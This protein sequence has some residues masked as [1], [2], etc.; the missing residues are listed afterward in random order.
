[1]ADI[2]IDA[3]TTGNNE[4]PGENGATNFMSVDVD[5]NNI[6]HFYQDNNSDLVYS[7]STDGGATWGAAVTVHA[8]LTSAWSGPCI[9]FDKWTSGNNGT[10]I[11]ISFLLDGI[12]TIDYNTLDTS[13]DTLSSINVV[14]TGLSL[15]Y[16][17][18]NVTKIIKD[19]GGNLYLAYSGWNGSAFFGGMY[20]STD[21]GT[22]WTSRATPWESDDN[23]GPS[24]QFLPANLADNHDLW[25]IFG[26]RSAN[27]YSLKT[28]DDSADSW[29]ETS[30]TTAVVIDGDTRQTAASI[31]HSDGHLIL[32][33]ASHVDNAA[34][35][36][37]IYDIN[38]SGSI[39]AKTNIITDKDDWS[40]PVVYIDQNTNNIYVGWIGNPD[41][42]D[43]WNSSLTI[44]KN[45]STDGGANWGTS[46]QYS[47]DAATDNKAIW[48]SHSSPGNAA[49]RWLLS[50]QADTAQ[51]LITNFANSVVVAPAAT[52]SSPRAFLTTKTKFW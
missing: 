42:S 18:S 16:D 26:D 31:R 20:R 44:W 23:D 19:R 2:T 47:Q 36:L 1:M 51:D 33:I 35:D 34:G 41:G 29:A 30:I 9:W 32:A 49:G 25:M 5:S 45:L 24:A 11:Y 40:S 43:T 37:L 13:N 12:G 39:T 3:T 21:G 7:K 14:A 22:I 46:A 50:W 52:T 27:E 48:S 38:G 6:Y 15:G 8:E 4:F 10:L 28:Y 17:N